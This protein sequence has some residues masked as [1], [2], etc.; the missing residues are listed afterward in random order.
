MRVQ[1]SKPAK[2]GGWLHPLDN[3]P[4]VKLPPKPAPAPTINATAIIRKWSEDTPESSY[5]YLAQSLGVSIQSLLNIGTVW[6]VPHNA[7]AF[8]MFD[9]YR[10]TI[11][12]RLRDQA[13]HKWAVTGSRQGLF[14]PAV[15][16]QET[17]WVCE[18]PTD[19]AAG[20]T[21]GLYC[22]GRP[23][24][25][26]SVVDLNT[27]IRQAGSRRVVILADN[28][29]P[30]YSGALDFQKQ[31]PIPSLILVPPAKDL[32]KFVQ[33]GGTKPVLTA[34]MTGM[35]WRTPKN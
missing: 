25:R 18:G 14:L 3:A 12:I 21:I 32:R 15:E 5:R 16:P 17:V 9:G 6:S 35:L 29:G 27:A 8:P 31:C 34:L 33:M 1:S 28:D 19:T 20:V 4:A 22:I 7:W 26:G 2:N 23:S 10:N 13:G 11:G 30:G 24:C